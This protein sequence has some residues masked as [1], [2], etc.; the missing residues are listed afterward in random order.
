MG[1]RINPYHMAAVL[2]LGLYART[3]AA[4]GIMDVING[5]VSGLGVISAGKEPMGEDILGL[6]LTGLT[7]IGSTV[8]NTSDLMGVEA[9]AINTVNLAGTGDL[10]VNTNGL[11]D[12]GTVGMSDAVAG[13][14]ADQGPS[15]TSD[16]WL[17]LKLDDNPDTV[18]RKIGLG[19]ILPDVTLKLGY[20]DNL[21]LEN[22]NPIGTFYT[23]ITPHSSYVG[24]TKTRK[25]ILDY[26]VDAAFY[27]GSN[28]DDYLDNRL[29]ASFEY[30]PTSRIFASVF[31]EFFDSHDGRG[32]G[33]AEGGT[34][35][36]QASL[37]E[38]HQWGLGG[39]FTYGAQTAR[40]RIELETEYLNKV[41]DTNRIFTFTRDKE[42]L[43]GIGR[44]I[45]RIRPKTSLLLEGRMT[46]H[47]YM[48]DPIGEPSLDGNTISLLTGVTWQATYKTTGFAKLGYMFKTFA[49]DRRKDTSAP[50]WEVGVDWK[51][52]SYSTVHFAT[53]QEF[54]ESEGTGDSIET[55]SM[56]LSWEH[57][58]RE[59]FK[60]TLDFGYQVSTI[61]ATSREDNGYLMAARADYAFRRWLNIGAGIRH[62]TLDSTDDAFG[63]DKNVFELTMDLVF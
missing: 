3:Y 47:N 55:S 23:R 4:D 15:T 30:D 6:Q 16:P 29:R 17:R 34:G 26:L 45:Y 2:L 54:A 19:R 14:S 51:P 11:M 8:L 61:A 63:Y 52:K 33:R 18:G 25:F 40:G 44:F 9:M 48:R 53:A 58:W 46:E 5:P 20:D 59:R 12:L 57:I 10:A 50:A 37:D 22:I 31:G 60:T 41:Y 7:G 21:T 1:T 42:E 36:T 43:S 32:K 39:K 28:K 56:Q 27:E 62:Q 24:S 35:I 38:W 13:L 49:S